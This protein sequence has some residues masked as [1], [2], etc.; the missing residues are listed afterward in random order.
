MQFAVV[1]KRAV[2]L[3][4]NLDCANLAVR[5]SWIDEIDLWH[6][7]FSLLKCRHRLALDFSHGAHL[8]CGY[9]QKDKVKICCFCFF[10]LGW[11]G[12]LVDFVVGDFCF[13]NIVLFVWFRFD[14]G[15]SHHIVVS[16]RVYWLDDW[17]CMYVQCCYNLPERSL[18]SLT[19]VFALLGDESLRFNSLSCLS[20]T[21]SMDV[22]I[23]T[24]VGVG[25]SWCKRSLLC[26]ATCA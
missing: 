16:G 20:V 14:P 6:W 10:V 4:I 9:L 18:R 5:R 3:C 12:W 7:I 24:S 11:F 21:L 26:C 23:W 19:W 15:V 25:V 2:L 17:I 22:A 1:T 13:C 8:H